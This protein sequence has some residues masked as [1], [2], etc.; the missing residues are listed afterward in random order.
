YAV[1]AT[2]G[3]V[4]RLYAHPYRFEAPNADITRDGPSSANFLKNLAWAKTEDQSVQPAISYLAQS[5]IISAK[6]PGH[7]DLY[8][9]PFGLKRNAL[10]AIRRSSG[11][12]SGASLCPVWDHAVAKED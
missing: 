5:Q 8:F 11:A 7:E 3:E 2:T 10:V 4:T 9:M 6:T 1:V 12:E